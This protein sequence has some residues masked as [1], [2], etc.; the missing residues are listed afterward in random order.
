MY[1]IRK[2]AWLVAYS[3]HMFDYKQFSLMQVY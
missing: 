1:A 2:C 3:F